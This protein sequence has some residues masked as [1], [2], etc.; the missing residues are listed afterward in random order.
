MPSLARTALPVT[1]LAVTLTACGGRE[2][3]REDAVV[4]DGPVAAGATVFVRTARGAIAVE[5]SPDSLV[6]V[7]GTLRWSGS[8]R[9]PRE[10]KLTAEPI[11]EGTLACARWGGG[12]CT[13]GRYQA[14]F[15]RFLNISGA[16]RVR[17]DFTVQVPAGVTLNL[18]GID[19][20][21]TA[22]ASA[23][24]RARTVN[25]NVTVATSVGPARAESVNGSVDLRVMSLAGAD[26]VVASTIN[27]NAYLY[28]SESANAGVLIATTNGRARAEFAS[29]AGEGRSRI[30]GTIGT[31]GPGVRVRTVNGNAHLG[32]LDAEGRSAP[33]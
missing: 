15:K 24:V 13:A 27:G 19:G 23:P 33:R 14:N 8:S 22:A 12:E 26:S 20:S 7:R 17:A 5:L 31:G 6:H 28:L 25:G 9:T 32:Q 2:R 11:A 3:V 21:I 18:I 16:R 1:V 29:L 10:V 4:Y 30:E